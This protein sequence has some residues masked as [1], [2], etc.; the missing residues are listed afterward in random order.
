V[1]LPAGGELTITGVPAQ[2]G[3]DGFWQVIGPVIGFV[4]LGEALPTVY[5]S[6]DNSSVDVVKE[7]A[8]KVGTI[9]VAVLFVG[10]ARFDEVAN[11]AYITLSNEA[12]VQAAKIM[13]S[14]TVIPVHA[15][16]WAHFSQS[17]VQLRDAFEAEGVADRIIVVRPGESADVGVLELRP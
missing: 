3:P 7:I 15:D 5:I 16:G 8:E 11:G 4:L 10:G 6:G 2:H 9:D 12:A 14:A 13:G 17:A 1:A